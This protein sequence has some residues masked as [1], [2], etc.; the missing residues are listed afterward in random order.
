MYFLLC[1]VHAFLRRVPASWRGEMQEHAFRRDWPQSQGG[2]GTGA[3]PRRA[4]VSGQPN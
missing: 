1:H 2:L 4:E 3:M